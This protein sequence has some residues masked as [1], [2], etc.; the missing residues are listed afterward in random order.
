MLDMILEKLEAIV[1][2][3]SS[4]WHRL[5]DGKHGE[6]SFSGFLWIVGIV[7]LIIFALSPKKWIIIIS[8]LCLLYGTFRCFSP[9]LSYHVKENEIFQAAVHTV[10]GM[11]K[12]LLVFLGKKAKKFQEADKK[13]VLE[14]IKEKVVPDEETKKERAEK[15]AMKDAYYIFEC[16]GCKQKVRIPNRG[17]KGRVAIICPACKT[18]FIRMRL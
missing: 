15:K 11:I 17:K 1:D 16:P 7:L 9:F 12:T 4:T 13:A 3:I 10:K 6:D 14:E 2:Y 5:I 8:L 18:R